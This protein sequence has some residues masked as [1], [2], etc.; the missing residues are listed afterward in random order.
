MAREGTQQVPAFK[1]NGRH[2]QD[3]PEIAQSGWINFLTWRKPKASTSVINSDSNKSPPSQNQTRA[4]R[5]RYSPQS[6]HQQISGRSRAAIPFNI[7]PR[8]TPSSTSSNSINDIFTEGEGSTSVLEVEN[9]LGVVFAD[10]DDEDDILP[11][12]SA[13]QSLSRVR[14][15]AKDDPRSTFQG[16]RN[17]SSS[18]Q[19]ISSSVDPSSSSP[20]T[21]TSS[22]WLA[23]GSFTIRS[24]LPRNVVPSLFS[25]NST[26]ESNNVFSSPNTFSNTNTVG[27][28]SSEKW[29]PMETD[30]VDRYVDRMIGFAGIDGS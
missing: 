21:V 2:L 26:K 1:H 12:N 14:R 3:Q 27:A 24:T 9:D 20:D 4:A 19:Q 28:I 10:E 25:N 16:T 13:F 30:D 29:R 6:G 18:S 11:F 5:S 23:W 15:K 8:R 17:P 22:S 7:G